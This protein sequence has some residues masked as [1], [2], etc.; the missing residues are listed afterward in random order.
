M[1]GQCRH[2]HCPISSPMARQLPHCG[3]MEDDL[4]TASAQQAN[5]NAIP[6]CDG[7]EAQLTSERQSSGGREAPR[8]Q[9][10]QSQQI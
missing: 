7:S 2:S 5:L 1:R 10:H 3:A 9:S 6:W 4:M 8:G